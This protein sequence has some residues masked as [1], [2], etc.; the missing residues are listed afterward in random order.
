MKILKLKLCSLG[1]KNIAKRKLK[2]IDSKDKDKEKNSHTI[3][4]QVKCTSS[5]KII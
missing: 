5:E 4:T 3:E 2:I 1:K